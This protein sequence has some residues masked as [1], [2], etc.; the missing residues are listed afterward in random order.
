MYLHSCSDYFPC[1]HLLPVTKETD[2][3][4]DPNKFYLVDAAEELSTAAN[5]TP[6]L[7]RSPYT[8]AVS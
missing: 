2:V 7:T 5:A 4:D 1:F 6:P 8:F 3:R